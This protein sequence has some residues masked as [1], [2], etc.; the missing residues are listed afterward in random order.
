MH[1]SRRLGLDL[2]GRKQPLD[3]G[4]LGHRLDTDQDLPQRQ[5]APIEVTK[6]GLPV[7]RERAL[8]D[9]LVLGE[10]PDEGYEFPEPPKPSALPI[11]V[12]N[13]SSSSFVGLISPSAA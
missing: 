2:L 4:I 11:F 9:L 8:D 13:S 5:V 1:F 10:E 12:P 6:V 7:D 3:R